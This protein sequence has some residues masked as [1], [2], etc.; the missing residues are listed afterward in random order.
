MYKNIK[1]GD[2]L[3]FI[4]KYKCK[5]SFDYISIEVNIAVNKLNLN[6]CNKFYKMVHI[7]QINNF[8]IFMFM[9]KESIKEILR[10]K[11]LYT[12]IINYYL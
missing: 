5:I 2:K 1:H 10:A 3:L 9:H 7:Y 11:S 4:I 8:S 6:L 12:I